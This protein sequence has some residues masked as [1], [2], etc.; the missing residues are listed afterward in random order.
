MS[1]R[2]ANEAAVLTVARGLQVL[3][4]FRSER[5]PLSNG[6]LARRT[7]LSKSTVSKLTTTLMQLGIIGH[8]PGG[9]QFELAPGPLS[10]TQ[11]FIGSSA[12]LHT[13]QP[14]MQ[15]L[16]DRLGVATSLAVPDGIDMLCIACRASHRGGRPHV[17]SVLPMSTTATG[18]ACLWAMPPDE[19]RPLVDRLVQHAGPHGN[20]LEAAIRRSFA[21][22]DETGTCCVPD[23]VVSDTF[24]IALPVRV[25]RQANLM[26]LNCGKALCGADLAAERQRIAP[27][28]KEVARQ[29]VDRLADTDGRP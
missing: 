9:R 18:R 4:A 17:G 10:T 7:G 3:R 22:L 20:S 24:S 19:R 1:T 16:A 21:E 25:G 27:A 15:E 11:A 28:M 29:V 6:E 14:L 5:S 12:L 8:A 23:G 2:A 26:G 13:V